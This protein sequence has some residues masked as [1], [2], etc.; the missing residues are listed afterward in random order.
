VIFDAESEYRIEKN[1]I[2][3]FQ[4]EKAK[5]SAFQGKT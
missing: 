1:L 4:D 5:F 2:F 3:T